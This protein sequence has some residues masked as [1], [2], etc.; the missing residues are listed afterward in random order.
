MEIRAIPI[1]HIL[2]DTAQ[3]RKYHDEES[4]QGLADSIR[5]HGLLNPIT[6]TPIPG[7]P[8]YRIVTGERRWRA[9][10]LARLDALPCVV[11][12]ITDEE[13]LTEQLIEN[14]QREDL[15]PLEKARA[16]QQIKETLNL[17]TREVA[18][19]LGLSERSV[20]YLLDLLTLPEEIGEAVVSS[21][22][23][24][25]AGQIT[26]KHARYL[27][28]LNSYPELQQQVVEHIQQERLNSEETEKLVRVIRTD[29]LRAQEILETPP[30]QREQIYQQLRELPHM[31]DE[32]AVVENH[33]PSSHAAQKVLDILPL[34]ADI[35]IE[36]LQEDELTALQEALH[37]LQMVVESLLHACKQRSTNF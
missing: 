18:Q 12:E 5:Q 36:Q 15:Q 1:D 21:P 32:R 23:R 11:R 34:L 27:K 22:N 16:I 3:P 26:E 30:A 10:K 25:S 17:T 9:A 31:D 24:P 4:L 33:M 7:S 6:V 20:N 37:S 2:A 29:P 8:H 35:Q 14:L 13:R 28:Q 19:R